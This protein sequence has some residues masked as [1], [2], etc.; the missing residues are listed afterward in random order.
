V[1]DFEASSHTIPSA[2]DIA[3]VL[4][5]HM[6]EATAGRAARSKA[7]INVVFIP[8]PPFE[9]TQAKDSTLQGPVKIT[10]QKK[11]G[12]PQERPILVSLLEISRQRLGGK[13]CRHVWCGNPCRILR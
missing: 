2:Q 9:V 5:E 13:S 10:K 12:A 7:A 11:K 3:W 4:S 6:A 1:Q 8:I